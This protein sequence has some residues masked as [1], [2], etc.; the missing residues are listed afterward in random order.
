MDSDTES[1]SDF[2]ENFDSDKI[3]LFITN[4]TDYIMDL[5]YDLQDRFPYFLDKARFPDIIN[6]VIDNIFGIYKNNKR[7][8]LKD[9]EY[10]IREYNSEINASIYVINNYLSKYKKST[11][12]YNVF[13]K[14]AYDFT[15][16]I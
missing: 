10:F 12:T 9:F 11:I 15:T 5:Y 13:T 7:Y 3:E 16:I 8:N 2:C 14:F 6:L 4:E 1:H